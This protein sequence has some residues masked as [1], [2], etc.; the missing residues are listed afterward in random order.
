MGYSISVDE[1]GKL[2]KVVYEGNITKEEAMELVEK[3]EKLAKQFDKGESKLINDFSKMLVMLNDA[4]DSYLL[5]AVG[6]L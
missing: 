6:I 5:Y 2:A 3:Y 4:S 1:K